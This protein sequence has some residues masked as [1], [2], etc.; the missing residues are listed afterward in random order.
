MES[1][2]KSRLHTAITKEDSFIVR[3]IKDNLLNLTKSCFSD[4]AGIIGNPQLNPTTATVDY[5][6]HDNYQV[7]NCQIIGNKISYNESVRSDSYLVGF[8][9][10]D[11]LPMSGRHTNYHSGLLRSDTKRR[12]CKNGKPCGDTCIAKGIRCNQELEI[13]QQQQIFDIRR[14]LLSRET[15]I[16][17]GGLTGGAILA[18]GTAA[19]VYHKQ[20]EQVI[21][22]ARREAAK[23]ESEISKRYETKFNEAKTEIEGNLSNLKSQVK[24]ATDKLTT[25]E[26]QLSET[27][28]QLKTATSELEIARKELEKSTAKT[29]SLT[30]ELAELKK[31]NSEISREQKLVTKTRD[32]LLEDN[33]ALKTKLNESTT[34]LNNQK[35][36]IAELTKNNQAI[37]K[38]SETDLTTAQI[39][40]TGLE[41]DIERN[42]ARISQLNSELENYKTTLSQSN[43]RVKQ[44]ES[45]LFNS[46]SEKEKLN[47]DNQA[48]R[49]NAEKLQEDLQ[50]LTQERNRL[51]SQLDET[52]KNYQN[53][54]N[55]FTSEVEKIRT[56][57]EQEK[58]A[59]INKAQQET[60]EQI[61]IRTAA[62]SLEY[63]Q[64][65]NQERATIL[66]NEQQANYPAPQKGFNKKNLVVDPQ[67]GVH[68]RSS[69]KN[70]VDF[71]GLEPSKQA[72]LVENAASKLADI[73]DIDA[74]TQFNQTA[75]QQI[76]EILEETD[77]PDVV[78]EEVTRGRAIEEILSNRKVKPSEQLLG[79]PRQVVNQL[80][81]RLA[82]IESVLA[83]Q[84]SK[85]K[86]FE[87][88][89]KPLREKALRS[90]QRA[91][92]KLSS[93][94]MT[95]EALIAFDTESARI[96]NV[97]KKESQTIANKLDRS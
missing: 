51:S 55:N 71:A 59:E 81:S 32:K 87:S 3:N 95:L 4:A 93:E 24:N 27:S 1:Q 8:N 38:S 82:G 58:V 69:I 92:A 88:E 53:L 65:L 33:E 75:R 42:Q 50:T 20:N 63:E 80:V 34:E 18:G 97:M 56:T 49:Q 89:F 79:N 10:H 43:D 25:A 44:L 11:S 76:L 36:Q 72:E 68:L 61:K 45:E 6:F 12:Q 14:Q 17:L 74:K 77:R 37:Q 86:Q 9:F 78:L 41:L 19:L 94:G 54:Q 26:T 22:N 64:R 57:T 2:N 62:I 66:D 29:E 21:N 46:T 85:E 52:T 90:Y 73:I 28:S 60:A 47:S 5:R 35:K 96:A 30:T 40:V 70:G 91:L 39:K 13:K 15:A 67:K 84:T 23:K 7:Y 31:T 48:G 16:L 83:K